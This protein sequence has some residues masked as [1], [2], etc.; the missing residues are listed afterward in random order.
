LDAEGVLVQASQQGGMILMG[1]TKPI[2]TP[3]I[4]TGDH[5]IVINPRR[6][7]SS[8]QK[9]EQKIYRRTSLPRGLT[10]S[11]EESPF[12]EWSNSNRGHDSQK[13]NGEADVSAS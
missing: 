4:D 12:I 3:F 2:Y 8:G 9:E 6:L 7:N 10:K 13:Q 1:K 5:V 11:G